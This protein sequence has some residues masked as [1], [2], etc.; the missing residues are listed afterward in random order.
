MAN[1][2]PNSTNYVHSHEPN[3]NDLHMAMD[4][5]S[6]GQPVIRTVGGDI[7]NSI[8]L[9]AGFGQ[10]HKFGAVPPMSQNTNGTIWDE[11]ETT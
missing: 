11:T 10:I 3:T 4:Y 2:N 7:Y 6:V 9:P 5:N 1:I 8:N